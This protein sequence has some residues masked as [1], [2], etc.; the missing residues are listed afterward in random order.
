MQA[1][2]E[3]A[4]GQLPYINVKGGDFGILPFNGQRRERVAIVNGSCTNHCQMQS[5]INGRHQPTN[6]ATIHAYK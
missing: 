1:C 2:A 3:K 6:A 4:R 5:T